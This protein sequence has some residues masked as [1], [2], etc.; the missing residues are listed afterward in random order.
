MKALFTLIFFLF[1]SS[2]EAQFR[3]YWGVAGG[4]LQASFR[5]DNVNTFTDI[6]LDL[7][8]GKFLSPEVL[9]GA[10]LQL[11]T[12]IR[13]NLEDSEDRFS[14]SATGL[15][16]FLQYYFHETD[17]LA[18]YVRP[19]ISAAKLYNTED[20]VGLGSSGDRIDYFR[21]AIG[22]GFNFFVNKNVSLTTNVDFSLFER[23][24]TTDL[25]LTGDV[26]PE[27]RLGLQFFSSD[28]DAKKQ[29]NKNKNGIAVLAAESWNIGG[30]FRLDNR[31]VGGKTLTISPSIAYFSLKNLSIGF[32]F[33]GIYNLSDSTNRVEIT[34]FMRYHIPVQQNYL[35]IEGGAGFGASKLP[36]TIDGQ[37]TFDIFTDL[38]VEGKVGLGLFLS[39]Y[40]ALHG[41]LRYQYIIPF[42]GEINTDNSFFDIGLEIGIQYYFASKIVSEERILD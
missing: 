35:F 38:I 8:L 13:Q 9:L 28:Y 12:E 29:A 14:T 27:F 18:F 5:N 3:D 33:S 15:N 26:K 19:A 4:S 10:G 6:N 34:P 7:H 36:I 2:V 17:R 11:G 42:E 30:D 25:S 23:L 39:K 22:G 31:M 21:G 40:T 16:V 32:E 37:D 41:G 20:A 1:L 24:T